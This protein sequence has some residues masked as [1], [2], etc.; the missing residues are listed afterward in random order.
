MVVSCD[1][2]HNATQLSELR[3]PDSHANKTSFTDPEQDQKS[4]TKV[5]GH[6]AKQHGHGHGHSHGGN[7]HSDQE[8][9]DA[10]IASIAWMVIMGDGMHNFSDGLAIGRSPAALTRQTLNTFI[11]PVV[12]HRI[13]SCDVE[14]KTRRV[15]R[16]NNIRLCRV[17]SGTEQVETLV[18]ENKIGGKTSFCT[19]KHNVCMTTSSSPATLKAPATT[20]S[21]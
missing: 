15:Y 9:K 10:G 17:E 7:C 14:R 3:A 8:M 20:H 18:N 5:N 2:D 4:P 6:K 16:N 19:Y 11:I 12:F 1:N 13:F 21:L